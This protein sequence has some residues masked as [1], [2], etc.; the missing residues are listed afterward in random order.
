LGV[1]GSA[2]LLTHTNTHTHAH[3]H[4]GVQGALRADLLGGAHVLEG[5]G[6]GVRA[7]HKRLRW[8]QQLCRLSS[9]A[10]R[11]RRR[12]RRDE[13]EDAAEGRHRD[14]RDTTRRDTTETRQRHAR[15]T[16]ETRQRRG[17]TRRKTPGSAARAS[18]SSQPAVFTRP[19]RMFC[20]T[21]PAQTHTDK[22]KHTNTSANTHHRHTG[23]ARETVPGL[24][25]GGHINCFR[26]RMQRA[27]GHG[28]TSRGRGVQGRA[29]PR[30]AQRLCA[31][32]RRATGVERQG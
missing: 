30:A 18:S 24:R 6:G 16:H 11:K 4:L 28:Y 32:M 23:W 17:L 26:V 29:E 10:E 3:T 5:G 15:D 31:G 2:C 19:S 13:E 25:D 9:S 12:R 7:S 22:H 21:M 27:Y 1:R 20:P 14:A 8:L